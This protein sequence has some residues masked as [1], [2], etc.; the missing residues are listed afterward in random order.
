MRRFLNLSVASAFFFL[1]ILGA[2][3]MVLSAF[4]VRYIT[5]S[6]PDGAMQIGM[7]VKLAGIVS[8]ALVPISLLYLLVFDI[9]YAW[10]RWRATPLLL[11]ANIAAILMGSILSA[12]VYYIFFLLKSG[13]AED[14]A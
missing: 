3:G 8:W 4:Y 12:V 6:D 7:G 11:A 13:D 1:G 14:L 9:F 10:L 2:I 5:S